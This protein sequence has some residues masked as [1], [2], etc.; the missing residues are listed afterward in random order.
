[1]NPASTTTYTVTGTDNGCDGTGT[2]TVT[3]NL[4]PVVAVNSS[5]VCAGASGTLTATGATTY[6]WTPSTGLSATTGAS[7]TANPAATTTYI[8]T[9][10]QRG[11]SHCYSCCYNHLY[12]DRNDIRLRRNS[13]FYG[14]SESFAG[15]DSEFS[16][17]LQ[18]RICY[19]DRNRSY[20][21]LLDT[22]SRAQ[23]HNWK[24]SNSKSIRNYHIYGYR[25][26][27]RL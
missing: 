6:S 10:T 21:V 4:L 14:N 17:Y 18:W 3:V 27:F 9:G 22:F 5:T 25:N 23:R 16:Y 26:Y 20:N 2:S 12:S 13:F 7:V 15:S 1:A 8:V 11:N 24:Y 19:S